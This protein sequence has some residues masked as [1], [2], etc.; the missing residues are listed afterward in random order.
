MLAQAVEGKDDE[1]HCKKRGSSKFR[2]SEY[3]HRYF[4]GAPRAMVVVRPIED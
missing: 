4:R 3:R 2:R 1:A